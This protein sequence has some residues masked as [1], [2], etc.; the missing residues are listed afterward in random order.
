[1]KGDGNGN[2]NDVI[3]VIR[4]HHVVVRGVGED[5]GGSGRGLRTR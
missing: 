2:G 5:E 3:V 1:M 4:C